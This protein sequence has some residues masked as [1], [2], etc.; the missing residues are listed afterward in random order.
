MSNMPCSTSVGLQDQVSTAF[1]GFN[2]ITVAQNGAYTVSPMVLPRERLDALQDHLMLVFTGISRIAADVA[3]TVVGNL[4]Q[5]GPGHAHAA[6]DGGSGDC[7]SDVAL[8]GPRR[9]RAAAEG[10]VGVETV[11]V[12][13]R[14]ERHGG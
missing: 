12:G 1:G 7:D 14:V 3:E 6:A 5:N 2:H 10:G 13:S 8:D 9:I 4:K 11:V